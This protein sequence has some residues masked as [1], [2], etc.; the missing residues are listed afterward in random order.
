MFPQHFDYFSPQNLADAL[1]LLEDLNG[2]S[3]ILSGGQSLLPAMKARNLSPKNV[4]DIGC[5]KELSFIRK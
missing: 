1:E 5:I 4:V 2:D 3:K